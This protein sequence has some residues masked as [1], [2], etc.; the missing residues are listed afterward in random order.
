[1]SKLAKQGQS[2]LLPEL[3]LE[4]KVQV[5]MLEWPAVIILEQM[6]PG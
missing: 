6:V 1:M 4:Q 2:V 5:P 3:K